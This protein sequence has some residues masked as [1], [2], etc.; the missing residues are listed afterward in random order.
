MNYRMTAYLI[1]VLMTIESVL[2]LI[3]SVVSAIY[4]EDGR[5]FLYTVLI[6]VAISIPL[7]LQ[8]PKNTRIG[9]KEGFSVSVLA[10]IFMSMFGALPFVFSGAIPHYVDA[11]FET[12]SGFTTTGASILTEVESL[13]KG[14]LFWRSFTHWVGGMG[15]LMLM[16]AIMPMNSRTIHLMRAEVPGPTKGKL[17]PR[18]KNTAKILYLIYIVLSITQF[19]ALLCTGMPV[20]DSLVTTFGTAGTGGFSV[21]NNSIAGYNNPAAEW[22]IGIFMLLFGMNFNVF[23][24]ILIKRIKAVFRNEELRMY[25]LI[26]VAAV[27]IIVANIYQ[28]YD[29]FSDSIREGF[30]HVASIISTTG[31]SVSDYNVWPELSKMV[32]LF[33]MFT[34]ACA[35][36]TAGGFKISRLILVLK[37]VRREVKHQLHPKSVNVVRMDKEPVPEETVRAAGNYVPVYLMVLMVSLLLVSI[38]GF[39]F[40]DTFTSVLTC[41]S[42]VGPG[43]GMVGPAGNFSAFSVLSKLVL[44]VDMLLGRLEI[45]PLLIVFSPSTWIKNR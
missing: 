7:L 31:F 20:Y 23:Y 42:N 2:L 1:G 6:I 24:L 22:I 13:P 12:V 15:V 37:N 25:L 44:S 32:L 30:F 5:P 10:W 18:M 26:T 4:G 29:N 41:V 40:E 3:S 17:V 39:A 14:I 38:D 35:G 27:G 19:I 43:F 34:G 11:L 36:S 8:K 28:M 9:A 45:F 16:L 21:L 33:V